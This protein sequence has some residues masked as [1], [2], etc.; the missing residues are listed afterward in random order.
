MRRKML[1]VTGLRT[2]KSTAINNRTGKP[3]GFQGVVCRMSMSVFESLV[4]VA[5][6]QRVPEG[7]ASMR[8]IR[9][10]VA[11]GMSRSL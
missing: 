10:I 6:I 9:S 7:K 4:P 2:N 1:G 3:F 11:R 5:H 8:S